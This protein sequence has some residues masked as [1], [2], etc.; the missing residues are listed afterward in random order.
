M[1][2]MHRNWI[3]LGLLTAGL[4]S[5]CASRDRVEHVYNA[6]LAT[7]FEN[8]LVVAVYSD[9]DGRRD[10]E[11]AFV[12][13]L[14]ASGTGARYSLEFMRS[15]ETID[16]E[17][18]VRIAADAG[19]DGVLISRPIRIEGKAELKRNRS[20]AASERRHDIPLAD[21]FRYDYVEFR[22]PDAFDIA[23][24]VLIETD[25]YRVA[26]ETN[27]WRAQSASINRATRYE[28]VTAEAR[29]LT[30]ALARDGLIP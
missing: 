27:V 23:T 7:P 11:T 13:A 14:R 20:S 15:T 1:T 4:V 2:V 10:F 12:R 3:A 18:L 24:S 5:G 8:L 29:A 22:D 30:S 26:D 28:I 25:L 16:R 19:A 6:D 17:A 9:A 21:F